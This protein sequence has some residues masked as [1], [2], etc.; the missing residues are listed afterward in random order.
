MKAAGNALTDKQISLDQDY[1]NSRQIFSLELGFPNTYKPR[2]KL[3]S[4][5]SVQAKLKEDYVL[6]L[7]TL[8]R[9]EALV[10]GIRIG[11]GKQYLTSLFLDFVKFTQVVLVLP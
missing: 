5:I 2:T 10:E 1:S 9:P 7:T 11:K 3:V 8:D 6:F 4:S